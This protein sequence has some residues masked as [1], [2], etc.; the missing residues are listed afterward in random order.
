[1][2][3]GEATTTTK[4]AISFEHENITIINNGNKEEIDYALRSG[5]TVKDKDGQIINNATVSYDLDINNLENKEYNVI[6]TA[7]YD[8]KV[9]T[10][11]RKVNVTNKT[12][13][14]TFDTPGEG[15]AFKPTYNG[16]YKIE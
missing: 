12:N 4:S 11:L 6:Y 1:M 13:I 7:T 14:T 9:I 16:V 15:H 3:E 5:L 8:D 2:S 10:R